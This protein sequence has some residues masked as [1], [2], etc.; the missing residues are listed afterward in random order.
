MIKR[1]RV[2]AKAKSR[3]KCARLAPGP[4]ALFGDPQLLEGEDVEAYDELLARVRAA[5]NP[6]DIIE[7][8]LIVDVVALEWQVLRWRRLQW[9]LIRARVL[10]ALKDFLSKNL[11]YE[12]YQ[13][14]FVDRLT[15][16]LQ[17]IL[18][19]TEEKGLA[20]TLARQ[21]AES[22]P[23][24]S[25]MVKKILA[26]DDR[27]LD[28]FLDDMRA[29]KAEELVQ[30]HAERDPDALRSVNECLAG[31]GVSMD[32]LVADAVQEQFD[33]IERIDQLA[34]GAENRRNAVL[35]EID[36][37][38]EALGKTVRQTLEAEEDEL[39]TD[40]TSDKGETP[41]ESSEPRE[42]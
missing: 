29:E 35:R 39:L 26:G 34:T 42:D 2:N 27:Q 36:R 7:D 37:R 28:I 19:E 31:A 4:L 25:E 18:P 14:K 13:E 15:E 24:A 8:M 30:E 17:E 3:S 16:V 12:M 40:M 1:V 10:E 6:L 23:A 9:V 21:C 22:E 5:V 32:T 33:Y 38:R 20:Q 11:E 41:V